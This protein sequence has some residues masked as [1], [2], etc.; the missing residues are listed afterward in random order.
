MKYVDFVF[1][2]NSGNFGV[3]AHGYSGD[4]C[5]SDTAVILEEL[6]SL[7]GQVET[8]RFVPKPELNAKNVVRSKEVVDKVQRRR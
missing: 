6:Q 1:D 3:E 2:L 8:V 7:L 5:V 4:G